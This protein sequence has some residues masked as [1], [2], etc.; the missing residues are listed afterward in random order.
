[1]LSMAHFAFTFKKIRKCP[2]RE[3][4][5]RANTD[6]HACLSVVQK[7][8]AAPVTSPIYVLVYMM[9]TCIQGESRF[10]RGS[11]PLNLPKAQGF[12]WD[13]CYK[14]SLFIDA[15]TLRDYRHTSCLQVLQTH[16]LPTRRLLH[17]H[18]PHP[19]NA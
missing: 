18:F 16:P 3:Y 14:E 6:G 10:L 19:K 7:H 8:Q 4:I 13:R 15:P 1:M 11:L 9:H 2:P 17:V 12:Y 5:L